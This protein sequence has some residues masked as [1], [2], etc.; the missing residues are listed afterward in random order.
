[1]GLSRAKQGLAG[2]SRESG[3][4]RLAGPRGLSRAQQGS[5]GLSEAQQGSVGL[6]GA[7]R[8]TDQLKA[9]RD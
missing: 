2:P 3:A 6:S 9:E 1:M 8:L 7:E 5:V 4:S